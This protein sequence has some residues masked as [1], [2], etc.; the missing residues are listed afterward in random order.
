MKQ[1]F[2]AIILSALTATPAMAQKDSL[3]AKVVSDTRF[4]ENKLFDIRDIDS[5]D[6][7]ASRIRFKK[8]DNT[9]TQPFANIEFFSFHNPGQTLYC[10]G[11]FRRMDWNDEASEWCFQRSKESEHFILFWHAGFGLDPTKANRNYAFDPDA[12]LTEAEKIYKVNTEVLGFSRPGSSYTLDHYKHMLFVRYQTEWLA[13]G[14]GYDDKVGAFWC[15]PAAVND[16][17]TLG[18]ELGHTF[19]YIV[20]CD[21]GSG[22]GWRQG[23][24][25][26]GEGG[27]MYWESCAQ[28]QSSRV[29]PQML[30]GGWGYS[31]PSDSHKNLLHEDP[32]YENYFH[33]YYWCQLHGQDFIGRLWMEAKGM[34]DP[35]DVYKRITGSD[36]SQFCDVMFEYARRCPTWDIDGLREY[37]TSNR[38][39][40]TTN[41]TDTDDGWIM[42]LAQ[43]C[44]ENYGFNVYRMKLPTGGNT[45]VKVRF[46]S[47]MGKSGY[48]AVNTELAGWRYGFATLGRGDKCTY[49]EVGRDSEGE[50]SFDVPS[51]T[52]NLWF[53]VMGAPTEHFH[54]TWDDNASNDE[55]WP[56]A[57]DFEGTDVQGHV[58]KQ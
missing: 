21:L 30:F 51:G 20:R 39:R 14:S 29:Y 40:F 48:R 43:N 12:L 36:Q 55:Q 41:T 17:T 32:R 11:E 5:I 28:W 7:N 45:T 56:Y 23:L 18:H 19:Q 50:L 53:V 3:W 31:Y 4:Y 35:V 8:E 58:K 2:A 9:T 44:P 22:H 49:S 26:N 47:E 57:I 46:R 16:V 38:N 10:P 13:T 42:P 6:F 33:Q 54:H 24:G 15:S 52:K 25:P 37:G 34:E 27:N 1:L